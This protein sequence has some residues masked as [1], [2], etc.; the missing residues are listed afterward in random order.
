MIE[1]DYK[2]IRDEGNEK[3]VF[4]PDRIPTK[5]DNVSYIEGPNS[6]GKSTFLHI[7]ALGLHGLKNNQ[8]PGALKSKMKSLL[9]S[10]YQDLTFK[11]SITNK[12]K[13]VQIRSEK[14]SPN[15]PIKTYQVEKDGKEK[16]ISPERFERNYNV[17]YDIPIDPT[18]RLKQLTFD[19]KEAQLRYGS[20]VGEL[21]SRIREIIEEIKHSRDPNR[22]GELKGYYKENEEN[23]QTQSKTLRILETQLNILEKFVYLKLYEKYENEVKSTTKKIKKIERDKRREDRSKKRQDK[24]ITTLRL[25]CNTALK[26]MKRTFEQFTNFIRDLVVEEEIH[27]L[28]NWEKIDLNDTLETYEFDEN[29]KP[30]IINFKEILKDLEKQYYSQ[31]NLKEGEFYKFLL[32]LLESFL[33]ID[34]ELPG[35]K[36][37][38]DFREEILKMKN[39]FEPVI[40]TG[41]N[42]EKAS[43]LLRLLD[44]HYDRIEEEYLSKLRKIKKESPEE[45]IDYETE[46]EII[47]NLIQELTDKLKSFQEKYDYYER[48]W[49]KKGKPKWDDIDDKKKIWKKYIN[50][51]ERQ[52]R[53]ELSSLKDNVIEARADIKSID[54]SNSRLQLQISELE[55]KK[56]HPYQNHLDYIED[57]LMRSVESL[58]QKLKV[59]FDDNI[60]DIINKNAKHSDDEGKEEYYNAIFTFLA[61]K[62]AYVRHVDQ[63]YKV[64]YIDLIDELIRTDNGKKIRFADMGTG[65]SQSAYLMGK[66]NTLDNRKIIALFDEVAMMD[67]DSLNPIYKR[68]NELYNNNDLLVGIVVQRADEVNV[69]SKISK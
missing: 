6:C 34:V 50:Y 27:H 32:Q 43:E 58:E 47:D 26:E 42:I 45:L 31:K 16:L 8:I 15:E 53:K 35:G 37:I 22:L 65:Q 36:K 18:K 11:I 55:K 4:K 40:V 39:D 69:I 12:D 23:K 52:L 20:R 51:S 3:R 14:N 7:L 60:R 19:I 2:I 48:E 9:D 38:R 13:T 28:N 57:T 44:E 54:T 33:D 49:V 24:R 56:E 62:I 41:E 25:G 61:K 17:I 63:E 29:L 10:S 64:E 46:N 30:E 66:L 59:S 5:L 21:K 68:F 67:S 1:S